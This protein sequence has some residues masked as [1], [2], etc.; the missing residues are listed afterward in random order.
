M[1]FM[2]L[3]LCRREISWL[4]YHILFFINDKHYVSKNVIFTIK[5]EFKDS[6]VNNKFFFA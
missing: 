3:C 5:R 1:I 4:L 2:G 6:K